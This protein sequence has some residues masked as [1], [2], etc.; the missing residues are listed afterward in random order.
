MDTSQGFGVKNEP[1]H[2]RQKKQSCSYINPNLSNSVD[3]P[4]V[5]H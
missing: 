4:N 2:H 5:K 3:G 1:Y